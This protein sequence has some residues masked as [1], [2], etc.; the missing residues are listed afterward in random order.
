MQRS[1]QQAL[2]LLLGVGLACGALGFS[3]DRYIG[4]QKFTSQFGPLRSRFYDDLGLSDKQRSTID[5]LA[6]QQDCAMKQLFA[7]QD[8][9]MKAIRSR[10]R[11][12][13]DS[14]FTK[15]QMTKLE[16][17]RKETQARREA[18]QQKEPKKTCSGN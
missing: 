10:F 17:R 3:A 7:P 1:K 6:F 16:L 15:D 8:S 12:Q 11:A 4:H 18:E 9:A 14:V 5:S 2:M 13:I